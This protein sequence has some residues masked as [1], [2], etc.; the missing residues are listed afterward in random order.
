MKALQAVL[1]TNFWLATH[2][3]CVTLGYTATFVAG[4]LGVAFVVTGVFTPYLDK[5][6]IK[7]LGQARSTVS[8]VA[9]T[10]S[11]AIA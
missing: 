8:D 2:V 11:F 9:P 6:W 1:D 5:T 3:V 7:S 10:L 4:F